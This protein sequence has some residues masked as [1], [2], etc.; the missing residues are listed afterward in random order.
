MSH[1][2]CHTLTLAPICRSINPV[3]LHPPSCPFPHQLPTQLEFYHHSDCDCLPSHVG[4]ITPTLLEW[5]MV[6]RLRL[7]NSRRTSTDN[8]NYAKLWQRIP[9]QARVDCEVLVVTETPKRQES[10]HAVVFGTTAFLN[11]CRAYTLCVGAFFM[12]IA[13]SNCSRFIAPLCPAELQ[14]RA[15]VY[16]RLTSEYYP[17]TSTR[18]NI[19]ANKQ[20][21]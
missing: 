7:Q 5:Y 14:G 11:R 15:C 20:L 8:Q 3:L 16:I 17:C 2:A 4:Y 21:L 1:C 10:Q 12:H 18:V 13:N 6:Q 19:D 9:P